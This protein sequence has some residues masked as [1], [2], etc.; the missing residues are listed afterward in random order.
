MTSLELAK[1]TASFF[2]TGG[3]VTKEPARAA[4]GA[5]TRA[6]TLHPSSNAYRDE[7]SRLNTP[8]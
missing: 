8:A 1:M 5:K 4:R 6:R 7:R 2:A 3:A